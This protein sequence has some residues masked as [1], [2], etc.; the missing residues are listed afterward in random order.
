MMAVLKKEYQVT[1]KNG[2]VYSVPVAVIALHRAKYYADKDFDGDVDKSLLEDTG[3][4]FD[5]DDF[6]I[7]DWARNK[8]NWADVENRATLVSKDPSNHQAGWIF[9]EVEVV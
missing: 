9:G 2:D 4:L 1:M 8:M 3:P 5:E 7:E 6:E